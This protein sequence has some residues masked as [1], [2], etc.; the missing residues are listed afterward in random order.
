MRL[1]T[2]MINFSTPEIDRV[3]VFF[4]AYVGKRGIKCYILVIYNIL[5]LFLL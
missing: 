2:W 5:R 3:H 4:K 1:R